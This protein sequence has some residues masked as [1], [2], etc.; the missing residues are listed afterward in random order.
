M[1]NVLIFILLVVAWATVI[2][3]IVVS[4][5][6]LWEEK[7]PKVPTKALKKV[8]E[9]Y[10]LTQTEFGRKFGVSR[11]KVYYWEI[12]RYPMPKKVRAHV[13]SLLKQMM[14]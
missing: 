6:A 12:G 10:G 3:I 11:T 8:R 2:G 13:V 7:D 9:Y 4:A 14:L 5:R 1:T